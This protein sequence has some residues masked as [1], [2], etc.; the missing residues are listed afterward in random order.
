MM[1]RQDWPGM[2]AKLKKRQRSKT[3]AGWGRKVKE[4]FLPFLLFFHFKVLGVL[5][6]LCSFSWIKKLCL[7]LQAEAVRSHWM[8][9]KL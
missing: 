2:W 6:V 9:L 7:S 8:K 5:F 4:G 3:M 1:G